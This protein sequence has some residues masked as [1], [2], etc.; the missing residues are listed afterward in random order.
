MGRSIYSSKEN[1]PNGVACLISALDI[2]DMT[3]EIPR[4]HWIAIPHATT[5]PKRVYQWS[6][7]EVL[8]EFSSADDYDLCIWPRN[9]NWKK[10]LKNRGESSKDSN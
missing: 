3:N 7:I 5:A 4:A 6:P 2:Y 9:V 8:L 10:D 1:I